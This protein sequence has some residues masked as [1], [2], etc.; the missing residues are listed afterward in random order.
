M[1]RMIYNSHRCWFRH[2]HT[3][4]GD[5]ARVSDP[6]TYVVEVCA[7]HPEMSGRGGKRMD[8]CHESL[9]APGGMDWGVS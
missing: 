1:E 6:A 8:S 5:C 3:S 4:T 7:D 2:W 9:A